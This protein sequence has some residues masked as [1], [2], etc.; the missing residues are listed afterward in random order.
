MKLRKI[1]ICL[2]LS[3]LFLCSCTNNNDSNTKTSNFEAMSLKVSSKNEF[4]YYLYTPSE[5]V[6]MS[7]DN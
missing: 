4:N 2:I 1:F 7:I 6:L 5:V 3:I